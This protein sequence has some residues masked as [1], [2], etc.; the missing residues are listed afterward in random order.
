[1]S[2]H[3]YTMDEAVLDLGEAP[4]GALE[5]LSKSLGW[6]GATGLTVTAATLF[7][8][9]LAVV[10]AVGTVVIAV[11]ALACVAVGAAIVAALLVVFAALCVVGGAVALAVGVAAAGLAATFKVSSWT[12]RGVA[13][14]FG[15]FGELRAQRTLMLHPSKSSSL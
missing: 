4:R 15:R 10:G 5:R 7:G 9:A 1:M 14:V 8:M 3:A 11:I 6:V 2:A 13:R 12:A